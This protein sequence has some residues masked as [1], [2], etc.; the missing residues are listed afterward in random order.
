MDDFLSHLGSTIAMS[1]KHLVVPSSP[2]FETPYAER[3]TFH[4]FILRTHESY[5]PRD[6]NYFNYERF[7]QQILKLKLP[8]QEYAFTLKEIFINDDPALSVAYSTSL[9]TAVLPKLNAAGDFSTQEYLYLDSKELQH[10]LQVLKT[11]ERAHEA[12]DTYEARHV[13]KHIPLFLFSLDT[14]VPIFIDKYYVAK[15]LSDMIIVVQSPQASYESRLICNEKPIYWDLRNPLKA[16][17]ANTA[18]L[19]GGVVPPHISYDESRQSA[20]QNWVWSVGDS[21]FSYTS[22]H[23]YFSSFHRDIAFR[24]Y[25]VYGLN[26]TLQ[27]VNRG[28]KLLLN[29]LTH[30]DNFKALEYLP[31]ENLTDVYHEIKKNWVEI[32]TATFELDYVTATSKLKVIHSLSREFFDASLQTIDVMNVWKCLSEEPTQHQQKFNWLIPLAIAVDIGMA[33]L[34]FFVR[35]KNRKVKVN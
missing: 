19:V 31:L 2:L 24:N 12:D 33:V 10:H 9:R 34:Y 28:V 5:N 16:A 23:Y 20:Y 4:L 1:L 14:D 25:V 7:K 29:Q 30:T 21:P 27:T 15:A 3:V 18:L 35:S 11:E 26:E 8:T 32:A 13:A 17:L 6:P 22:S